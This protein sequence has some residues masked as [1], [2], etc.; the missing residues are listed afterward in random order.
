MNDSF[1]KR[2]R[3][4]AVAGWWTVLIAAVVLLIQ[5]IVYLAIMNAKPGWVQTLWGPGLSWLFIQKIW[6]W[7]T[8][9][10]KMLIWMMAMV[11]LWL[12]LWAREMRREQV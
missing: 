9:V 4:A 8:A 10:L 12:T 11:A 3:A 2:V 5:W 1:E 7:G 6:F